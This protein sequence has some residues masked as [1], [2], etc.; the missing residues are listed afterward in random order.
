MEKENFNI[1]MVIFIKDNGK[2]IFIM[3]L[4]NILVKMDI[5]MKGSGFKAKNK[6]KEYKNGMMDNHIKAS[7]KTIRKMEGEL[8]DLEMEVIMMDNFT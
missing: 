8:L 5:I 7:L 1:Q 4:G 6:D 2:M 3:G